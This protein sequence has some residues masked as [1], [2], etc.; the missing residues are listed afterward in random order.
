[1]TRVHRVHRE[2]FEQ[3]V[4]EAIEALPAVFRDKLDNVDVVVEPWPAAD[5]LRRAGISNP[6]GL[7]GFY[8]G[9]PQTRRTRNYGLVLPDKIS[10]YQR[11]IEAR[12]R[13]HE[14]VRETVQHV[15][16][17]EIAHHFGIDDARL[18][19]LGAY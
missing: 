5:V 8:Q 13:T 16:R 3:L 4:I 18:R 11:P 14:D 15:L 17:H 1:M 12:C 6:Y 19:A 7:L 2:A 9:V 10:L